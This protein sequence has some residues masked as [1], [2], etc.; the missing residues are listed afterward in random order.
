LAATWV[1]RREIRK[2][3]HSVETTAVSMAELLGKTLEISLAEKS[4][5]KTAEHSDSESVEK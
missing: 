4:V 3:S 5:S 2:E 1:L